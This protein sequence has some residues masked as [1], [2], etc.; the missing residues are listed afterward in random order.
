MHALTE[1]PR[2]HFPVCDTELNGNIF[3]AALGKPP[4]NSRTYL[5]FLV[6][7]DL[8]ITV[9]F[10]IEMILKMIGLGIIQGMT[11]TCDLAGMCWISSLLFQCDRSRNRPL[12][13]DYASL[14]TNQQQ[15]GDFEALR[16]MRALRALR[17]FAW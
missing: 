8:I 5:D 3:N 12:V 10:V 13:T 4:G 9:I 11:H 14:M 7:S 6:Y 16:S 15:G 2:T 17:R 1:D